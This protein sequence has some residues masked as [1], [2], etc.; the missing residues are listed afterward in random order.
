MSDYSYIGEVPPPSLKP[1]QVKTLRSKLKEQIHDKKL[2]ATAKALSDPTKLTIYL[3]LKKIPEVS[4]GDISKVTNISQSAVSHALADLKKL[5]IIKSRR[6]GQ[7]I[8]YSLNNTEETNRYLS[9]LSFM[10]S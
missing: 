6:C 2:V 3:L 10:L 7:L 9:K 8:C 5:D 4:V 1:N